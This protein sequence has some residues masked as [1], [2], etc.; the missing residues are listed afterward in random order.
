MQIKKVLNSSVV[1][2]TDKG[3]E[4]FILLGKGI[5]YGRKTGENIDYQT[6]NRVYI[7]LSNP[8]AKSMLELFSRIPPVYLDLTQAIIEDAKKTLHVKLSSHIYLML[9]EHLHFAVERQKKG[10]IV[11]N[12]I[13]WDIKHFYR[14]E[15]EIGMRGLKLAKEMLQI[16][17]PEEEAGNI[18][19]HLINARLDKNHNYNAMRAVKFIRDISNI[20]TYVTHSHVD[21]EGPNYSRFIAHLQ[22]FAERFYSDKLMDSKDDFLYKQIQVMYPLALTSAEKVRTYVVRNYDV[23][24]PNEEVAYL[25]IHVAR[26]IEESKDK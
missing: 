4:D 16:E 23:F 18:A 26:L 14:K 8:E 12:Q 20:L 11:S 17:L 9:T 22:F 6:T 15:F 13:F 7:P 10:L 21:M 1:L 24:L 2:V 5:G 19:F 3:S 25:A